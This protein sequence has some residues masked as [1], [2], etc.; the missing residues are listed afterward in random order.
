MKALAIVVAAALILVAAIVAF[1]PASLIDA[2]VASMT[3]NSVRVA[4][5]QGT[6]FRGRGVIGAADGQWRVPVAWTLD[7]MALLR[8]IFAIEFSPG[9][10]A[11]D[12][13][14]EVR[15]SSGRIA[16]DALEARAPGAMLGSLAGA[17]ATTG[18]EVHVRASS[19]TLA[20]AANSGS[21]EA[22]WTN[23]RLRIADSLVDLGTISARLTGT[24]D[25]FNGP[26]SSER[27]I[28]GVD[29]TIAL[30]SD[31]IAAQLRLTP[32]PAAP[33]AL[34]KALEAVGPADGGG[35]VTLRIDRPLR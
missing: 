2:R 14:G 15:A 29:G 30:R 5:T 27:G 23:A 34:R 11:S 17:G 20:P 35:T 18:G 33:D 3:G 13:R 1:A 21:I 19:L 22:T 26:I 4:D 16:I 25:A 24:G 28:V 8:G 12:V 32:T 10:H 6:L 7:A 31:R 9:E